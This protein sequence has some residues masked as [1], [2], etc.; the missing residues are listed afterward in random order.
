MDTTPFR[1]SRD[2]RL[3]LV[4]GTVFAFGSMITYVAIPY[5]V[6]KLTD[7]NFMVGLVGAVELVPLIVFGLWGGALADHLDRRRL[8]VL[9]GI[10]QAV[11]VAGL[12]LNSFVGE[13]RLWV[14]FVLA[15]LLT[16]TS[17]LQRPARE[18]LM[19]RTVKHEQI[20]A[21]QALTSLGSQM[22]V[23]AGPLLGGVLI[24]WVGTGWCFVVDACGL[25]LATLMYVAMRAYPHTTATT[26]PSIASIMEG[27]RYGV[28]RR[29]LLGTYTVDIASMLLAMPVVLFP[30][31]AEEV[32]AA[33]ERLGLLY[34]AGTIG[35]V[36]ATATSGWIGSVHRHGAAI[37]VSAALYGAMVALAGLSPSFWLAFVFLALAGATDMVSAIFRGTVWNQT[38]PENM[39]GRLAGIEMLSYSFGP[40]AG[41]VRGGFVADAWN[42]RGAVVSGGLACV[43]GVA[44]TAA[45]LRTFWSYDAR[46]DEH[47]VAERAARA[48]HDDV[49]AGI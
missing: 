43:V 16:S 9:Y 20:A 15:V 46:T 44:A 4:A 31:M 34:A 19:P 5:Q 13:P 2:F 45:A 26:P 22:G 7:S 36:L 30:A 29:D 42:V 6:Y 23:L 32:F 49:R 8:L 21:A 28:G 27:V 39:R 24:A 18:A 17:S 37:T 12:A 47:A 40:R 25:V 3:L 1:E 38:I 35:A 11:I 14:L 10:A 33:P 41:Q 48:A